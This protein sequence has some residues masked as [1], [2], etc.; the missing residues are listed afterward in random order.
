MDH[1]PQKGP[2]FLGPV[3][4]GEDHPRSC[5]AISPSPLPSPAQCRGGPSRSP[6]PPVLPAG[7]EDGQQVEGEKYTQ[8]KEHASHVGLSWVEDTGR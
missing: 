1:G 6:L 4:G 7:Q 2:A 8:A 5:Q 3:A